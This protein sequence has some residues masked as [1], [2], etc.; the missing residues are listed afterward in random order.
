MLISMH[1]FHIVLNTKVISYG[2]DKENLMRLKSFNR[3]LVIIS[4]ILMNLMC[5][6]GKVL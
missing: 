6:L 4:F 5:D 2:V 3:K 1:I